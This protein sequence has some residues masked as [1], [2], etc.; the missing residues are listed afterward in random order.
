MRERIGTVVSIAALMLMGGTA[1]AGPGGEAGSPLPRWREGGTPPVD[2]KQAL[3]PYVVTAGASTQVPTS[4]VIASP[5][6]ASG[7][8]RSPTASRS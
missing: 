8:R 2:P 7:P 4:G 3:Y 1:L 6:E 5:P